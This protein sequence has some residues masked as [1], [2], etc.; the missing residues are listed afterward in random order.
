MVQDSAP[1]PFGQAGH[2][3]TQ[4]GCIQRPGEERFA[5]A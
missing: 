1:G 5:L 3:F 2:R 4:R